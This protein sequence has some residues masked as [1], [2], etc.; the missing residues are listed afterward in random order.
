MYEYRGSFTLVKP[1]SILQ[2]VIFTTLHALISP[3]HD[4]FVDINTSLFYTHGYL[5]LCVESSYSGGASV[6]LFL[7]HLS[8]LPPHLLPTLL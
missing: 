6:I 5:I 1:W 2:S 3:S 8:T 7:E 4:Y